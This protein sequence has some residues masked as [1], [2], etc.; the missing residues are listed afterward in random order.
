[1]I[2]DGGAVANRIASI[3][4]LKMVNCYRL[5]GEEGSLNGIL[6]YYG[7]ET[8]NLCSA[9]E[10]FPELFDKLVKQYALESSKSMIVTDEYTRRVLTCSKEYSARDHEERLSGY[11]ELPAPDFLPKAFDHAYLLSIVKYILEKLYGEKEDAVSFEEGGRDWFGQG[12]ICGTGHGR[13]MHFPYRILRKSDGVYEVR[14]YNALK[15][16]DLLCAEIA[17]ETE[18]IL[19]SFREDAYLFRGD[20]KLMLTEDP[21]LLRASFRE[22]EKELVRYEKAC[23]QADREKPSA[24]A[25][26]LTAGEDAEWKAFVLPW[27]DMYFRAAKGK[28][29]YGILSAKSKDC[30]ISRGCA[31]RRVTGEEE[32]AVL[33]GTL[34]FML[35]ERDELAELHLLD[36]PYPRSAEYSRNY[37]G[38]IFARKKQGTVREKDGD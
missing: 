29:E 26:K 36:M 2:Q 31:F 27:G 30:L 8:I 18:R 33:F 34:A 10:H 3:K 38:K 20:L 6:A 32:P 13:L 22:A 19:A 37:A 7:D 11:T 9:D 23:E 28:E 17:F 4:K 14:L 24:G 1:M 16:G 5:F 12:E 21:P 35:Y 15:E 25:A